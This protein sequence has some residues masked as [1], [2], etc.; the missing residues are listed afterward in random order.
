[1][2]EN[3]GKIDVTLAEQFLAD[4]VDSVSGKTAPSERTLC[5]HVDLSPRGMGSWQS[6]FGTAGA[7]QNNATDTQMA[8]RMEFTAS[9]GHAFGMDFLAANHLQPHPNQS[10]ETPKLPDMKSFSCPTIHA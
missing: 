5:G 7:V 10:C 4:H 3:K 2:A 8:A 1:M 9:A 6:P